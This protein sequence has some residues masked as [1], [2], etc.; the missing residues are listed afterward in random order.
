MVNTPLR[1][2]RV[3]QKKYAATL[4]GKGSE[5]VGGLW[6]PPGYPV[7]YTSEHPALSGFEKMVH[8]GIGVTTG[9]LDYL[10][11]VIE[12]PDADIERVSHV[13]HDPVS[14]GRAWLDQGETLILRVPSV[15]VP[16]SWH[17]LLNVA[18]QAM[19]E[20]QIIETA[21]FVFD[22]RLR[23]AAGKATPG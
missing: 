20:V 1:L 23:Q 16:F 10:V 6:T 13:P 15:V 17:Y 14:V 7:L 5:L 22:E 19:K 12:A 3:A 11:A 8:A 21:A 4:D 2:Y 9:P 18:H